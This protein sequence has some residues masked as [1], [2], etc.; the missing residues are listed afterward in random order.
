MSSSQR[1]VVSELE[2]D[3]YARVAEVRL[4]DKK[5]T[6]PHFFTLIRNP[7][8]FQSLSELMTENETPNIRGCVTRLFDARKI[9][10]T[11]LANMQ[12]TR[13]DGLN[14]YVEESFRRFLEKTIIV[15]DPATEYLYYECS[16]SR[17]IDDQKLPDPIL[18]YIRRCLRQKEKLKS[19]EYPKWKEAYHIQFWHK[20]SENA[21]LRNQMIGDIFDLE[22]AYRSSILLPP[23]PVIKSSRELEISIKI[24]EVAHGISM[25]RTAE[26]ASYF[27]IQKGVLD[28]EELL[29]KLTGYI[30]NTPSRIIVLK[31][32]YLNLASAGRIQQLRAYSDFL[33]QLAFLK[34]T[35]KDKVLMVLENGYQLF[36]STT[37]AFDFASTSMTGYDGDSKFGYGKYGSWFDPE[38]M[39]HVPFKDLRKV[40]RNNHN[41]LPCAHKICQN[42]DLGSIDP[43]SWNV[44]R[45]KH[46]V[47]T[48][49]DYMLMIAKAIKDRRIELAIDKLANSDLSRLKKL[50]PRV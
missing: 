32:K 7:D 28:D 36:P 16:L 47:L 49:N 21:P 27:I 45:R 39:V 31:F 48:M 10:G 37:V 20:I 12:Q 24:N 5:I 33:Q 46:Y 18:T 23:V 2:R 3:R 29:N 4:G 25:G 8:E 19:K 17:W 14:E 1:L 11:H 30:S 35:R 9:L 13:M 34:E 43:D 6:T 41:S 42:I 38:Q 15:I 22:L 44:R 40:Y 50:I 26:C